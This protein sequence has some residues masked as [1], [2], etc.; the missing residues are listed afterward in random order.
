[1]LIFVT[2]QNVSKDEGGRGVFT[3]LSNMPKCD[4]NKVA[5]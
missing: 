1:M 4:F 5:N 3:T 2:F